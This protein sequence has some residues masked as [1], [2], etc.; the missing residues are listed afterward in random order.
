LRILKAGRR[1]LRCYIP[2]QMPCL[3]KHR[4]APAMK[5]STVYRTVL[6][7]ITLPNPWQGHCSLLTETTTSELPPD[8]GFRARC[9]RDILMLPEVALPF[10]G[11]THT[12]L[13]AG[14]EMWA[15]GVDIPR[16]LS[17]RAREYVMCRMVHPEALIPVSA[18][19]IWYFW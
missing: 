6:C 19:N 3:H 12:E 8:K 7:S 2:W 10:L 11:C 15:Q 14:G 18:P 17:S 16:F 1:I 9:A 13:W 5:L 4:A